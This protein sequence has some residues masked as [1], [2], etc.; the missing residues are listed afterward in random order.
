M[1]MMKLAKKTST[2]ETRI[3]S[4]RI[5]SVFIVSFLLDPRTVCQ[6]SS[7]LAVV[8]G[9][10]RDATRQNEGEWHARDLQ[11]SRHVKDHAA[12]R[13]RLRRPP[14]SATRRPLAT[15]MAACK[16]QNWAGAIFS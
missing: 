9:L 15:E 1:C 16:A 4:H 10:S 8:E 11:Q 12:F 13:M 14:K 6:N 3:G 2:V 5:V 7:S